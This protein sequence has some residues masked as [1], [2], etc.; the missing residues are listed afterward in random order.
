RKRRYTDDDIV[1]AAPWPKVF[2]EDVWRAIV[3]KLTDPSRKTTTT[4][5]VAAKYL[6][7]CIYGCPCGE[8]MRVNPRGTSGRA[9]VYRCE[10]PGKGH[11]SVPMAEMDEWVERNLF[12][13][14]SRP[15]A[16]DLVAVPEITV[17][18]PALRRDLAAHRAR[19]AKVTEDFNEDR[20]THA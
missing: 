18:V 2:E 4:P 3:E 8:T 9:P 16:V 10:E 19:L 1:G 14:M 12:E 5:G 15:D 11:V 7:T 20:I 6:G 13:R 17:D